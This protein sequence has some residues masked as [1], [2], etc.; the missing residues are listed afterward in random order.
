[1]TF[2]A[3]DTLHGKLH[4]GKGADITATLCSKA[5]LCGIS[6]FDLSSIWAYVRKVNVRDSAICCVCQFHVLLA[7]SRS[8]AK[9]ES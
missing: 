9:E 7:E 1:L 4:W 3:S 6:L 5:L 8:W 2:T